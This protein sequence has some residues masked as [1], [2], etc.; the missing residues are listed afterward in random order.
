MDQP[1]G[2]SINRSG[3]VLFSTFPDINKRENELQTR[4]RAL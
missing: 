3:M 4:A 1:A 2:I